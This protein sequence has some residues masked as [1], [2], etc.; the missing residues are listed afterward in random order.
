M[1]KQNIFMIGGAKGVGKTRL[2]LDVSSDLRLA[3]IETGKVV[4]DYIFQGLPLEGLT[5]Y[6]TEEILSQD[7]NLILDTHYARYSDKEEPNKQFRRG[8]EPE[9]LERLLKKFNIF[10]CLV[11]VPLCELEQRRR[12]DPKKRVTNPLYIMQEVEFNRRGYE[13]Y[14]QEV[15]KQPFVLINDLYTSARNNLGRWITENKGVQNG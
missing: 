12:N 11:E 6:I 2:T 13:L 5:D 9:D 10:P 7:R 4:F 1:I 3:R 8:L 15:N 14:L